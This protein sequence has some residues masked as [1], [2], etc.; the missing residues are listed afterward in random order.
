MVHNDVSRMVFAFVG[1][2]CQDFSVAETC[3]EG[4]AAGLLHQ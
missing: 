4:W 2:A 3:D 1:L